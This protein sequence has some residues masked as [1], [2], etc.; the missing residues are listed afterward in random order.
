MLQ[1]FPYHFK[2]NGVDYG[3]QGE[4]LWSELNPIAPR[5]KEMTNHNRK[6][7][8]AE[9]CEILSKNQIAKLP[10]TLQRQV[11]RAKNMWYFGDLRLREL[12]RRNPYPALVLDDDA[13]DSLYTEIQ[14]DV[15]VRQREWKPTYLR[16]LMEYDWLREL[17]QQDQWAPAELL[18]IAGSRATSLKVIEGIEKVRKIRANAIPT[19]R[20]LH[21]DPIYDEFKERARNMWLDDTIEAVRVSVA[22]ELHWRSMLN[23]HGHSKAF[24]KICACADSYISW[25]RSCWSYGSLTSC[26]CS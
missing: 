19:Q 4:W 13:M 22:K 24:I 16:H 10:E 17:Q 11:A 12:R 23:D 3:E 15:F 26:C 25:P 8:L 5:L 7:E 6:D 20:W 18:V 9:H 1:N 21:S 14:S 2:G